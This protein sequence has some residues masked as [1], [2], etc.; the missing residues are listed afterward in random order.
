MKGCSSDVLGAEYEDLLKSDWET[1]GTVRNEDG[2]HEGREH[3]S[4]GSATE[5]T[6]DSN[7]RIAHKSVT[8]AFMRMYKFH[9][10]I[11]FPKTMHHSLR[12]WSG[13]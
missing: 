10:F 8:L 12:T 4:M 13:V 9:T 1:C 11:H 2:D 6:C 7:T 3:G 5:R